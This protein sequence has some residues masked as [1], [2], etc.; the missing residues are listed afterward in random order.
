MYFNWLLEAFLIYN[1]VK[2]SDIYKYILHN[3]NTSFSFIGYMCECV[4]ACVFMSITIHF[5]LL[6]FII[7]LYILRNF[8]HN[9]IM[10]L[11]F[12]FNYLIDDDDCGRY[13]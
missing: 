8:F 10:F 7:F 12:L 3:S 2:H 13:A 5:F 1:E 6:L 9:Y 4:C 11:I